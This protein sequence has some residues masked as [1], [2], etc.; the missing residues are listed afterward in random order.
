LT[1]AAKAIITEDG[2]ASLQKRI[3]EFEVEKSTPQ[4]TVDNGVEGYSLLLEGNKSLLAERIDFRCRC[5]D[6][7]VELVEVRC[8][9]KKR[10]ADLEAKVKF[11]EANSI[12]VPDADEKHLKGF[13][14]EHI[15][16]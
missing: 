6:L 12:D 8:D 13:D 15:R 1:K 14:D 11:A 9:A 2:A 3:A 16:D 10:I 5:E 7:R 4:C